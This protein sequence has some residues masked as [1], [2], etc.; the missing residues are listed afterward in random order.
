MATARRDPVERELA[1][2]KDGNAIMEAVASGPSNRST[3]APAASA[4]PRPGPGSPS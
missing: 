4:G 2:K 3:C 1:L